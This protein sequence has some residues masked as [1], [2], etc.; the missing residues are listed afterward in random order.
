MARNTF[1]P[2]PRRYSFGTANVGIVDDGLL[3]SPTSLAD[4]G[5][6]AGVERSG[7]LLRQVFGE[8]Q[9]HGPWLSFYGPKPLPSLL[10]QDPWPPGY[11]DACV[12]E[13]CAA[14]CISGRTWRYRV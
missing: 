12:L 4:D 2:W 1:R 6:N 9:S 10:T 5:A 8:I 14:L 13:T 11:A 7:G 3:E